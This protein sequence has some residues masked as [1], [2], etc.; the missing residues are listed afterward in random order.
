MATASA[1]RASDPPP[2][3]TADEIVLLAGSSAAYLPSAADSHAVLLS[4][5][6]SPSPSAPLPLYVSSLLA[7]VSRTPPSPSLSS[8]LCSLLLSFLRLFRSRQVPRD[9]DTSRLFHLFSLH[10]PTLDKAQLCSVLDLIV[11]D[12]EEVA[13]PD[14]ALPLDLLPRCLDLAVAA[15][16][17]AAAAVDAV[18]GKILDTEWPKAVLVKVV[19][20]LREFPAPTRARASEF[21]E[22]VFG[23]MK[24]VDVQDLPSL[25]YQLL[26]LASKGF[27]RR[28]VIGGILSFFGSGAVKGGSAVVRQVEGTVLMHFNFA[29]K[30]DPSL[31][32]E[33]LRIL[34]SNVG[35]FNHFDAAV[36]LSIARVRRLGESSIKLLRS[37]VVNSYRDYRFAR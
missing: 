22:K 34:R 23:G 14:D 28:A 12:L 26:L 25:A 5:L 11:S 31:G 9:G 20:L 1:P 35:V 24:E 30:Q 4:H 10:L 21:L 29:V 2:P 36:L 19:S 32:L 37:M 8:F 17:E 16:G 3:P 15:G 18:L 27:N 13:D 6:L 33:V 7:L